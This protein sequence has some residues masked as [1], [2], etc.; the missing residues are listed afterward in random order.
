MKI[1]AGL[2][3][4]LA[5]LIGIVPQFTDCQSQGRE[6]TLDNGRHIPMKCHW[7]AQA[8]V[9]LAVPLLFTGSLLAFNRRK[10]SFRNLSVL[11]GILGIFVILLP[12]ALIGV[13]GNP[14][15]ICN[16][17]MKPTLIMLGSLLIALSIFGVVK[18][19]RMNGESV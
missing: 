10:E 9:A 13:C 6:L 16:S 18:S 14:D 11:G 5:L 2:M 17:V 12:T 3:I 4:V 19:M 15:M 7:T 1:T 8:E